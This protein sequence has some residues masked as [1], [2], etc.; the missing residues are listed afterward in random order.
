MV[1]LQDLKGS[2]R[3][4]SGKDMS[5]HVSTFTSYNFN[6]LTPAVWGVVALIRRVSTSRR[7]NEQQINIKFCMKL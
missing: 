5:V 4:A 7:K 1:L 2:M 6:S 3:Y